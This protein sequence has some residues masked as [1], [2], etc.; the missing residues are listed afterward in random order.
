MNQIMDEIK[1]GYLNEFDYNEFQILK[2]ISDGS[3]EVSHAYMKD[4]GKHVVLKFLKCNQDEYDKKFH[5]EAC[6]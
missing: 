6:F 3:S 2:K 5:T 4:K 1:K